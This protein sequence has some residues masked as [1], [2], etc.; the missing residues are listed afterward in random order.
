MNNENI[1]SNHGLAWHS[2]K[3]N[4]L[5]HCVGSS[6]TSTRMQRILSKLATVYSGWDFQHILWPHSNFRLRTLGVPVSTSDSR[7]ASRNSLT[8]RSSKL[9]LRIFFLHRDACVW[10]LKCLHWEF[11]CNFANFENILEIPLTFIKQ[12]CSN[13]V[14]CREPAPSWSSLCLRSAGQQHN[15]SD[16]NYKPKYKRNRANAD[17]ND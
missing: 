8:L 16:R 12:M 6:N 14:T 2:S 1:L 9:K 10:Q 13:H 5:N 7:E 3:F 4:A 15:L 17:E 11:Q